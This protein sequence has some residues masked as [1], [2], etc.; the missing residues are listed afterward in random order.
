M[1][2][3]GRDY[4]LLV[5]TPQQ[6][7]NI[8]E[9]IPV[10]TIIVTDAPSQEHEKL[11]QALLTQHADA[12]KLIRRTAGL[13]MYRRVGAEHWKMRHV[14]VDLTQMLGRKITHVE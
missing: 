3:S 14:E 11:V 5:H 10:G 2:W 8:V 7:F 13:S 12:W 6:A 4:E 1:E 9:S